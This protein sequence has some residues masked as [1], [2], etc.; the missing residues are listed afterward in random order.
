[1]D[2]GYA[3]DAEGLRELAL[4]RGARQDRLLASQRLRFA[5]RAMS[6][7][8]PRRVP[9]TF[10][11]GSARLLLQTGTHFSRAEARLFR[12]RIA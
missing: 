8:F 10:G 12:S 9:H 3:G 11:R 1:M 2:R 4:A 6:G 7:L 5:L